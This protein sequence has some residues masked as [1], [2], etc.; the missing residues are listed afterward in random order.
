VDLA[1][2]QPAEAEPLLRNALVIRSH[3]PEIVPSRRR[4]LPEDDWSV[5][6]IQRLLDQLKKEK[7]DLP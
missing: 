3:A 7:Q 4:T 6:A 5:A 2:S 1:R